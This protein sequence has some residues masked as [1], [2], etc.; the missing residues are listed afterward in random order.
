MSGEIIVGAPVSQ[1]VT[2]I[3][4]AA[5]REVEEEDAYDR[6]EPVW[7]PYE[8]QRRAVNDA[9]RNIKSHGYHALFMEMGTGKTKSTIDA[10]MALVADGVVNGLIVLA[11]KALVSTWAT[12]ELVKHMSVPYAVSVWDGRKSAKAERE[13]NDVLKSEKLAVFIINIEAFQTIPEVMRDR[14][15]RFCKERT[16]LLAVDE[17]SFIKTPDAARSKAIVGA[18]RLARGRMILTGTEITNSPLDLYMQ[19]NFLMPGFWNVRNYFLFRARYAQLED[20]YGAGGRTFKK[21]SGYQRMNELLEKIAPY[22]TRAL[23]KDCLDLPEK[24]RSTIYVEMSPAQE[25]IYS[26]LK[27]H[28]AAIVTGAGGGEEVLTVPNKIA[29]FTKFRQIPG[30]TVKYG[31]E[32][33]VIDAKPPKLEALLDDVQGTDEQAIIWCS[34]NHEI[35]LLVEHLQKIAP[36]APYT[37][38]TPQEMREEYKRRFQDGKIRFLVLNSAAGSFGLNLQN[39]HIQY[40]YSRSLS[41]DKVWQGEDRT[42]RIGQTEPC[43]YKA[44]IARG[45]VDERI[46]AILATKTALREGFQS[47]NV[48]DSISLKDIEGDVVSVERMSASEMLRMV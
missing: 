3:F 30:G 2:A 17:S 18:G 14:F 36:A 44:I 15:H 11:P 46:E 38:E 12:E 29:L 8:H 27:K 20:A 13:F 26:S 23:K 28:L 42:H 33:S 39:C 40:T 34:F 41:P 32:H 19:F 22:A 35:E 16:V 21:V 4:K 6:I 37:G 47:G 45:T 48:P 10:F 31:S 7:K 9:V 24:I 25:R 1:D 5:H 43:V